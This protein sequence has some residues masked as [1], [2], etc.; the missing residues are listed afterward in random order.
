K[1]AEIQ[2]KT[3]PAPGT[4][5]QAVI[6]IDSDYEFSLR[7]FGDTDV[8]TQYIT[9]VLGGVSELYFRQLGVSLTVS[10]ISLYTTPD[11]PWNAPNP[12]SGATADVLCEFSSFWQRFRPVSTYPRNGAVF[13]TGKHS[14]DIGGQ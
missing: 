7:F 2:S 10:S 4:D 6:A 1:A 8:E 12:H 13:F 14:D 5:Y 9:T 11:D 3:V